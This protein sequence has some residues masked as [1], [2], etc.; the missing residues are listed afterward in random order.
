MR[1]THETNAKVMRISHAPRPYHRRM[2]NAE[3]AYTRTLTLVLTETEWR[4]L[5]EI[6]PDAVAWLQTQI[7]TRLTDAGE[8]VPQPRPSVY[9]FYDDE[10]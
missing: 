3:P 7:R 2:L 6:E 9:A 10:Y 1:T 5:R 4:A 8:K